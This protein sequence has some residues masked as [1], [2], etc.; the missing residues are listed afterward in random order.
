M[1]LIPHSDKFKSAQFHFKADSFRHFGIVGNANHFLCPLHVWRGKI[2]ITIIFVS[3]NFD[4][5]NCFCTCRH[6]SLFYNLI[7]RVSFLAISDTCNLLDQIFGRRY[8]FKK[9][10]KPRKKANE[11][12]HNITTCDTWSVAHFHIHC[13]HLRGVARSKS[14]SFD[15]K[16]N[17][18]YFSIRSWKR[19]NILLNS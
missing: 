16:Y 17:F 11:S 8:F 12:K 15:F 2:S 4:K 9:K 19:N 18:V 13:F 10:T 3:N 1:E 7:K 5:S 14:F 6:L